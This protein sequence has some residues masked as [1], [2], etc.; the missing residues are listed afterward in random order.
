MLT[1]HN[2]V[3]FSG[4]ENEHDGTSRVRQIAYNRIF[5]VQQI[6]EGIYFD[7]YNRIRVGREFTVICI[8]E[9]PRS[10]RCGLSDLKEHRNPDRKVQVSEV[11]YPM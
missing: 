3:T 8:T 11:R 1:A 2:K 10:G 4:A 5:R 7:A 9:Y 6:I